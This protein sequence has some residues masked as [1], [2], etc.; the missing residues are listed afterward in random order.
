MALRVCK[1]HGVAMHAWIAI[2]SGPCEAELSSILLYSISF[3]LYS[4]FCNIF[5]G[6][7][8]CRNGSKLMA[9]QPPTGISLECLKRQ[10]TRDML[11]LFVTSFLLVSIYELLHAVAAQS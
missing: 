5:V 7:K 4:C 10:A 6:G 8:P 3:T 1:F 9:L 2:G 11:I